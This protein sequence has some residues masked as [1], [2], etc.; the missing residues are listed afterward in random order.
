MKILIKYLAVHAVIINNQRTFCIQ[1]N[2][3]NTPAEKGGPTVKFLFIMPRVV[4]PLPR[5]RPPG[6]CAGRKVYKDLMNGTY[7]L[8]LWWAAA[9]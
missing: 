7:M 6:G 4:P 1:I 3:R 9:L 8:P 5:R 2:I